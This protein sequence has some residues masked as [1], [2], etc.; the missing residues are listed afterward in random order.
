[1]DLTHML[2]ITLRENGLVIS[3]EEINEVVEATIKEA[4]P[5]IAGKISFEE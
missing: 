2:A 3:R 4:S 1:M 5:K